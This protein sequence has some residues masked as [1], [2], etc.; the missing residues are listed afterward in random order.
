MP[1]RRSALPAVL[2]LSALVAAATPASAAGGMAPGGSETLSV[3]LPATWT[4]Q[5]DRL[6]VSVVD[7]VQAENGCL[8]P[9]RTA[10]DDSCD[11]DGGDLAG[12][13]LATV[14]A[15]SLD[16]GNCEAAGAVRV[17]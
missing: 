17:A 10:G 7:L 3:S 12:Q 16:G 14:A 4:A 5:A 8:R 15:G 6:G 1:L 13:L 11:A 2:A 9:E